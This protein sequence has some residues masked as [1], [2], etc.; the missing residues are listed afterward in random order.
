MQNLNSVIPGVRLHL[1]EFEFLHSLGQNRTVAGAFQ[2]E[3]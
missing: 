3:L 2:F 1:G